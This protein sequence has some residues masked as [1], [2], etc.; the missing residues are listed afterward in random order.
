M[1]VLLSDDELRLR[2]VIVL[3]LKKLNYEVIEASN[4]LQAVEMAKN[5]NP[6]VIVLDIMMPEMDGLTACREI[7][8]IEGFENKPI[9]MLTAKA[10]ES[11]IQEGLK[12]G[13][14]AYLTK[15]FSPKELVDKIEELIKK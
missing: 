5:N 9:I 12:N 13:A 3:H 14:S 2:K 4:G 11:D 15:P 1:K 7:R 6:D 10:T 8:K